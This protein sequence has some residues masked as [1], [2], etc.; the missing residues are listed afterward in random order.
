MLRCTA[1]EMTSGPAAPGFSELC[2][3]QSLESGHSTQQHGI[4]QLQLDPSDRAESSASCTPLQEQED[5]ETAFLQH[6]E[7]H[8]RTA[9]TAS[10]LATWHKETRLRSTGMCLKLHSNH[11]VQ[12]PTFRSHLMSYTRSKQ[13]SQRYHAS[14]I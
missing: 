5:V 13:A 3:P 7:L 10:L 12:V 4:V 6:A 8:L 1:E 9:C 2:S 14:S 11:S